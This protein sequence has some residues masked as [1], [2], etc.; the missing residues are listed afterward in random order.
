[1]KTLLCVA[2]KPKVAFTA[3]SILS[4]GKFKS[5]KT[6][7]EYVKNH[8]FDCKFQGE[9]VN[10]IFTAVKGHLVNLEFPE[11]YHGWFTTDPKDLFSCD[12]RPVI[13]GDNIKLKENLTKLA[14]R[15][16]ILMLWLDNDRE[17]E[18]ISE[19][20][21]GVCKEANSR[22][23]V[24]R[25]R[26][27]ALS[28]K[29]LVDAFNN[30]TSINRAD[31]L[32]CKLRIETDLRIGSA[33]T[34]FQTIKLK[35]LVEE[36]RPT[37]ES[38]KSFISYGPCQF[39][40]LG[41]IV[42]A[43]VKNKVFTPEKFWYIS[44]MVK[45]DD[46]ICELKWFRKRLFCKLSVFSIYASI[47]D[48]PVVK[49][50]DLQKK[51]TRKQKP[52]PLATVE[53]QRRASKYLKIDPKSAMDMA[54]RIYARGYI[55]YPRTETDSFPQNFNFQ[56][57]V[58]KLKE[59]GDQSIS[60]YAKSFQIVNPRR[61]SHSDNAHPP[62]YPL[63]PSTD[64]Y[65]DEL[66]LY[67]FIARHFLASISKDA[68]GEETR[69]TFDVN[70]EIFT[71]TGLFIIERNYLDIYPYTPWNA[72]TIPHFVIGEICQ[73]TEIMMKDG[74]TSAPPLLS[75][76]ELIRLMDKEGIGT[77]ATMAQHIE[78][79]L[80]RHYCEKRGETF[81][82]T[83]LGLGLVQGYQKMGFDFDKPTLRADLERTMQQVSKNPQ[84]F[85][86]EKDRII[87][88]YLTA[89]NKVNQMVGVL[90]NSLQ[91]QIKGPDPIPDGLPPPKILSQ[92][93]STSKSSTTKQKSSS[94][95]RKP[96]AAPKSKGTKKTKV[97]REK[98]T[99]FVRGRR[100]TSSQNSRSVGDDQ[101]D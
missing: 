31:A 94:A 53:F 2:E 30:P 89:Y 72:K 24:Y 25:A 63:K 62:I 95:N 23:I 86:T 96:R 56:E 75:E 48:N 27:A 92:E 26:F 51:P 58:D 50:I 74:Y 18:I 71:L 1:M 90:E 20:V 87:Q 3:A 80:N 17:G 11:Q 64:L 43:F 98:R 55:S 79:I 44:T 13:R 47:L 91:D 21:E 65:G 19:E 73:A 12:V 70:D 39:P 10:V 77:D 88:E 6:K 82:P 40:T 85:K 32:A 100:G 69:V 8:I 46:Q 14:K 83:K 41:F 34:R 7:D 33:F 35:K 68:L 101:E 61:G 16:K 49:V 67:N 28:K 81:Y 54:E 60:N 4:G 36:I 84:I 9:D 42:D 15:A 93:N 29:D 66:R 5:E 78:T 38:E 22:I 59:S 37:S 52:L 76:P 45:K 57:I 99:G 97:S